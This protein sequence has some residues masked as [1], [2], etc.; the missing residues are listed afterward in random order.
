MV[1]SMEPVH[2]SIIT[3]S[4]VVTRLLYGSLVDCCEND[5]SPNLTGFEGRSDWRTL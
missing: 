2:D 5:D 1:E 3:G 4:V